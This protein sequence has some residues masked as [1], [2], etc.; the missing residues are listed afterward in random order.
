MTSVSIPPRLLC[1]LASGLDVVSPLLPFL[2]YV[3]LKVS[4]LVNVSSIL[5]KSSLSQC[6]V[7]FSC[8]SGLLIRTHPPPLSLG[9]DSYTVLVYV[10]HQSRTRLT[11]SG[12]LHSPSGCVRV[13]TLQTRGRGVGREQWGP[14]WR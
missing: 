7:T 1:V 12:V 8:T 10:I 4:H 13:L 5:M 2:P 3:I 11:V 6:R 14:L 9:T